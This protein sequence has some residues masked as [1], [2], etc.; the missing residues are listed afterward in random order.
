MT[1]PASLDLIKQFLQS[2]DNDSKTCCFKYLHHLLNRTFDKR[3]KADL[4]YNSLS[5]SMTPRELN[6]SDKQEL[7]DAIQSS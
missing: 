2:E 4:G 1:T 3:S 7:D 6:E 5:S